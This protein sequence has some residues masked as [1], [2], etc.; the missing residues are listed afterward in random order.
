M[1]DHHNANDEPLGCQ[2]CRE[3]LQDYLDGALDKKQSLRF[4]L[5]LRECLECQQ[6][7]E[8][9][10]GLYEMLET[11]PDHS[12]PEGFDD[13]ILASIPY[14]AYRE[15]EAIRRPRVAVFLEEE[16]LPAWV[17]SPVTRMTGLAV[18]AVSVTSILFLDGAGIIS[19]VAAAVGVAPQVVVSLQGMGRR[20]SLNQSR[21]EG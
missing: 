20:L 13:A 12:V 2:D 15:M 19:V 1:R 21:A 4:F 18:A 3:G 16:F 17:R 6:E 8:R 10:Q 5:H 7:H 11:L 9:L 14:D